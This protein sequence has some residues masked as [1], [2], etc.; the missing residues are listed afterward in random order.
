M[1]IKW[2]VSNNLKFFNV[3]GLITTSEALDN[4][5]TE[6]TTNNET[7]LEGT[8]SDAIDDA[9]IRKII[10]KFDILTKENTFGSFSLPNDLNRSRS[11]G[12]KI[13]SRNQ[14]SLE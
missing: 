1:I 8:I 7:S 3:L 14:Y 6:Y 2:I 11:K 5:T 12:T 9:T 13:S 4:I 10:K